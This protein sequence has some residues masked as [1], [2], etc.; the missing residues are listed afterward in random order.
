MLLQLRM[1]AQ[2]LVG[3]LTGGEPDK[4]TA[5]D[6]RPTFGQVA[7][8]YV[9]RK[10][11][12]WGPH[13]EATA[14]SIINKHLI[15]NLGHRPVEELAAGEI[16]ALVNGMVRDNACQSLLHKVVTHSRSI[17]DLAEESGHIKKNPLRRQTVKIAY[18][19]RKPTSARCLSL[20]E[21]RTLLAGLSGRDHLIVRMFL[22][23]GLH[24]RELFA[25]RRND[26]SGE[27]IR[28]DG[29][30]TKGR[31][32]RIDAERTAF[33]MYVPPDLMR[34]L[35]AWM[36]STRGEDGDWLFPAMRRH[37]TARLSPVSHNHY[38]DRVLRP[39]AAR[40]GIYDLDLLT[41]HRTYTRHFAQKT[42][43]RDKHTRMSQSYW[44][45]ME[46]AGCPVATATY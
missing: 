3:V 2:R 35:H 39:L 38:R 16:Q 15:A 14:K 23:L 44:E 45:L 22:Q 24:P 46:V 8:Q 11:R 27:L 19:S 21:C 40:A 7:L 1:V 30:F 42:S 36:T 32:E 41:L 31:S 13:A 29:A 6:T 18:Q 43:A 9:A 37:G 25:L 4:H 20:Q 26:V 10:E 34:E 12:Q 17:L 28:I 33:N 5:S